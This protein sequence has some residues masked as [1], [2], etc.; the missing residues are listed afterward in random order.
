[1]HF[2][3]KVQRHVTEL[4]LDVAHD[5][6][7][8]GGGEAV[9]PL[10]EDLHQVVGEVAAGQVQTEYGVRQGVTLV[11]GHGVR[12]A[13]AG[14]QH[15]AGGAAGGVQRQHRLYGHVH[16]GRVERLEHDLYERI[17]FREMGRANLEL[18]KTKKNKKKQNSLKIK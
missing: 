10:G 11:D 16:C 13:V 2:L 1:M 9:P 5:L 17:D 18:N 6:P 8:G 12:H 4:L 14:V 3:F 15:D 7:L